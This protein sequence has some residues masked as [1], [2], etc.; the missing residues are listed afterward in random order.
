MI[1]DEEDGF[2]ENTVEDIVDRTVELM[3]D[4]ELLINISKM[5]LKTLTSLV[6]R[7]HIR[8]GLNY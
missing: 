6:K 4:K 2:V 7:M 8:D 3:N 5:H 1:H